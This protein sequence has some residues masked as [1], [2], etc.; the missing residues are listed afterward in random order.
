MLKMCIISCIL[1]VPHTYGSV[2]FV[3]NLRIAETTRKQSFEAHYKYPHIVTVLLVDQARKQRTGSH[4]N[5]LGPLASA[6]YDWPHAYV[7]MDFAAARISQK[8]E[9]A[10]YVRTQT[11]DVLLSAGF[12]HTFNKQ[13]KATISGYLGIPTHKDTS[14]ELVQFGV[15]HLA[16]GGQL[17]GAIVYSSNIHNVIRMALRAIHY[18]PRKAPIVSN[19]QTIN[20]LF[21]YGNLIDIFVAHH[22]NIGTHRFEAGYDASFLFG[23]TIK[24]FIA[25]LLDK[26]RYIRSSFY[27][28]YK[29][30]FFINQL[31]SAF[32]LNLS[33]GFDHVPKKSGNKYVI[34]AWASLGINF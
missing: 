32:A 5:I 2:S 33:Y 4:Q 3:Y 27:A 30:I 18:F 16:L 19:D 6:V 17:D 1:F 22:S 15:G 11:D 28:S 12:G 31:P 24:P 7:R 25:D 20:T 9:T 10:S 14:L 21:G 29:H 8:S 34:N 23:A 13:V 26:L